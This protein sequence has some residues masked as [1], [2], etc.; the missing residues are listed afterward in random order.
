M[1][2]ANIFTIEQTISWRKSAQSFSNNRRPLNLNENET[3]LNAHRKRISIGFGFDNNFDSMCL[4]LICSSWNFDS[5]NFLSIKFIGLVCFL[6]KVIH[7]AAW[8]CFNQNKT[9]GTF[10]L[11][12]ASMMEWPWLWHID[13]T[14]LSIHS[15][16]FICFDLCALDWIHW[17]MLRKVSLFFARVN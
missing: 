7:L 6:S 5:I 3:K 15:G 14:H 12:C 8:C 17:N 2:K 10:K 9:N 16:Q 13:V 4:Y 11:I 1:V